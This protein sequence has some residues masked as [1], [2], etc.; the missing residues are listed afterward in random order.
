MSIRFYV[1]AE[2]KFG[3]GGPGTGDV[4]VREWFE[5]KSG[6]KFL[7][8]NGELYEDV[9]VG[10]VGDEIRA[11]HAK[12]YAAFRGEGD[13][14][15]DALAAQAVAEFEASEATVEVAP[16]EEVQAPVK[17]KKAKKEKV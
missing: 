14:N 17:V 3:P 9:L 11:E 16:V 8:G 1:K 5:F 6:A 2:R 12:E 13:K 15:F 4:K 7:R 10:L